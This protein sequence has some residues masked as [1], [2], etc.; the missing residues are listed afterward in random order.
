MMKFLPVAAATASA[1]CVMSASLKLGVMR[2][3]G[4][5]E[6]IPA[7]ISTARALTAK[8]RKPVTGFTPKK[9]LYLVDLAAAGRLGGPRQPRLRGLRRRD[10]GMLSPAALTRCRL[11]PLRGP[12]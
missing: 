1:T 9:R 6:A 12:A 3:G 5:A 7:A 11:P 2:C 10:P 4:C 8:Q